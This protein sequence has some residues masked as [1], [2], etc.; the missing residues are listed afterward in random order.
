MNFHLVLVTKYRK[1]VFSQPILERLESIIKDVC[2][3]WDVTLDEFRGEEDQIHLLISMHPSL[4]PS[5]FINNLKTVSSRRLRSEY[6]EYMKKFYWKP[7]LWTRAY[8]LLST[9][10][11]NIET[12]RKYIQSQGKEEEVTAPDLI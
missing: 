1:K 4:Q 6:T 10:G 2:K 5:K 3:K 8:C 7:M 11:A 9:G 12:I